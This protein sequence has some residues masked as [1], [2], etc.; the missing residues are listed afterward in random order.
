MLNIRY[1]V[2]IGLVV[3]FL[4][5]L[6]IYLFDFHLVEHPELV[7]EGSETFVSNFNGS[8]Q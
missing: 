4:V 3:T 2:S 5:F 1:L 8:I 6:S 7:L